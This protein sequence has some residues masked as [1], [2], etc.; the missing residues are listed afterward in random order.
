MKVLIVDDEKPARDRLRQLL[1]DF[2]DYDV[3][4]EASNGEEAVRLAA[5][6]NPDIARL[7]KLRTELARAELLSRAE[8][9]QESVR[10]AMQIR[11]ELGFWEQRLGN[12]PELRGAN[13]I[14]LDEVRS[15]IPRNQVLVEYLR[16]RKFDVTRIDDKGWEAPRYAA[17]V[18]PP[19]GQGEVQLL[20]TTVDDTGNITFV[21]LLLSI[22]FPYVLPERTAHRYCFH[23]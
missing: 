9:S 5:E 14:T 6:T 20:F 19:R 16:Y 23:S 10:K 7:Y 18:I 22:F 15:A 13:W 1:E 8:A 17:W 12:V 21:P 3:V 4:A 11:V 2:D